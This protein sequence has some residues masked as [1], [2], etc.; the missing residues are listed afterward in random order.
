M[1]INLLRFLIQLILNANFEF[2]IKQIIFL[3]IHKSIIFI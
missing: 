3:T 2:N 1:Y